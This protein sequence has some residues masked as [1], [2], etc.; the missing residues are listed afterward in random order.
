MHSPF[1]F[2]NSLKFLIA[3]RGHYTSYKRNYPESSRNG[4][5][6]AYGRPE[7]HLKSGDG[8]KLHGCL[9]RRSCFERNSLSN[10]LEKRHC[11]PFPSMVQWNPGKH[12]WQEWRP[13]LFVPAREY[14]RG[15]VVSMTAYEILS[16]IQDAAAFLVSVGIFVI[17]LLAFLEQ[18]NKHK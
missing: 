12:S 13:P 1:S 5:Y 18:R 15:E 3:L 17:T 8:I 9:Y 6:G 10:L 2:W 14:I 16:T 11:Q 7:G 4:F